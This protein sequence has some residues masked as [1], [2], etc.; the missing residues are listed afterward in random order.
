M[1]NFKPINSTTQMKWTNSL[2]DTTKLTQEEIDNLN[3]QRSILKIE[4]VVSNPSKKTSDPNSFTS[5]FQQTFKE[6][7]NTNSI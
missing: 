5:E 2:K 3:N 1:K 6:K 7:C 4:F